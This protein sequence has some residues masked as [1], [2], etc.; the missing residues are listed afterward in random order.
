MFKT[1]KSRLPA[2]RILWLS[3][4]IVLLASSRTLAGPVLLPIESFGGTIDSVPVPPSLT[5]GVTGVQTGPITLSLE[6]APTNFFGLDNVQAQGQIDVMLQLSSPLFTALGES[7]VIRIQESGAASVIAS[8]VSNDLAIDD[9]FNNEVTSAAHPFVAGD[10]GNSLTIFGGTGFTP[11]NY[12]IQSVTGGVA[13]LNAPAGTLGSTGGTG[14]FDF[15]FTAN[16][17]GGGTVATGLFTG[18]VFHNLNIYEGDLVL[19]S[20]IVKPHSLVPWH[21][22]NAATVTFP[23][24]S[25]VNGIGGSGFLTVAPEPSSLVLAGFAMAAMVAVLRK[26]SRAKSA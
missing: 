5:G 24:G 7:P 1:T 17:T 19:G 12:L 18:T 16:L 26:R 23:D 22:D 2:A 8:Q 20:W 4:A 25:T 15:L 9:T 21:I 3:V 11:G 13:T 14:E 6:A 10:V